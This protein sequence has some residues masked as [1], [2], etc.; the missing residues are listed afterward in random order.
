MVSIDINNIHIKRYENIRSA[1]AAFSR[2]W[3]KQRDSIVAQEQKRLPVHKMKIDVVTRWGSTH[4]MDERM[5]KRVDTVRSVLSED[6]TSTHLVPTWQD[7]DTLHSIAAALKLLKCITDA[8]SGKS[9]VT[10]SAVKPLLN[11]LLEKVL[12]ADDN[13]TDLI[14][15][16]KERIKVDLELRYLDSEFDHLLEVS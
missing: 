7:H 2:S 10:I 1:V 8:L 5:L 16:M 15:E 13:D 4:D 3:K 6:R 11:H 12:V 14:K 9:C